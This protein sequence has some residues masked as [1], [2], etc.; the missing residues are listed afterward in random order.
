MSAQLTAMRSTPRDERGAMR[1]NA[2]PTAVCPMNMANVVSFGA[3][4]CPSILYAGRAK[5]P[6]FTNCGARNKEFA[7][8]LKEG[9]VAD[10]DLVGDHV[11]V[12]VAD[13]LDARDSEA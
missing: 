11:S 7:G 3:R 10:L 13:R 12:F 1:F 6:V 8:K 4:L 5:G 9:S 2:K